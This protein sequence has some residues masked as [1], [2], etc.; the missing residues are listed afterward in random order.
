MTQPDT[1]SGRPANDR[2]EAAAGG[3][4]ELD[5][6]DPWYGIPVELLDGTCG[7]DGDTPGGCG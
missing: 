1:I 4:G 2:A 7:Y 5:T 3:G 6:D